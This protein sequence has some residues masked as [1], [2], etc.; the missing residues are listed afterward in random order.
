M[1]L[2]DV[3][4]S[5]QRLEK[6]V[7]PPARGA[8]ARGSSRTAQSCAVQHQTGRPDCSRDLEGLHNTWGACRQLHV[9]VPR[10]ALC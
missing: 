4:G 1:Y 6:Q 7:R 9:H 5:V 3:V 10:P 8:A 2:N